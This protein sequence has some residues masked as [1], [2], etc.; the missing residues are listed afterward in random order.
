M[1]IFKQ[2]MNFAHF[3]HLDWCWYY[4]R[5]FAPVI[6][7]KICCFWREMDD[8]LPYYWR[9]IIWGVS[10]GTL[11]PGIIKWSVWGVASG[12]CQELLHHPLKQVR[13]QRRESRVKGKK[14]TFFDSFPFSPF[15]A[16]LFYI[17][18]RYASLTG[19]WS[20]MSTG[21]Y[22][23]LFESQSNL[24]PTCN[25]EWNFW[26]VSPFHAGVR[27]LPWVRVGNERI[28][29]ITSFLGGPDPHVPWVY[30]GVQTP[31]CLGGRL[32]KLWWFA[33]IRE[34]F[35]EK[36]SGQKNVWKRSGFLGSFLPKNVW[37]WSRTPK[38][39]PARS[40]RK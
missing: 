7:T 28:V 33:A 5:S 31:T 21:V 26:R 13:K 8:A 37:K 10:F 6:F 3:W 16:I 40:A 11:I 39:P 30:A 35:V 32:T 12:K 25:E 34:N 9:K 1:N 24:F 2:F 27:S 18:I 36:N 17:P 20:F 22:L 38:S 4:H 14:R 15:E 29:T 23:W 19:T